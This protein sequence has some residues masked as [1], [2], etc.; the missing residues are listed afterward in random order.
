MATY[1][2]KQSQRIEFPFFDGPVWLRP[3]SPAEKWEIESRV[4]VDPETGRFV[5]FGELIAEMVVAMVVDEGGSPIFTSADVRKID[6]ADLGAMWE[7]ILAFR[8]SGTAK[9]NSSGSS[10]SPSASP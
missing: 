9:K 8:D 7:A 1:K 2:R 3:L 4:P 6:D 10:S 5:N